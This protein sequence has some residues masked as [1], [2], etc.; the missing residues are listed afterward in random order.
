MFGFGMHR[1]SSISF[2]WH[3][4]GVCVQVHP[5]S[6][7]G[8]VELG[9]LLFKFHG[10]ISVEDHVTL[11]ACSVRA[12]RCIIL[13]RHDMMRPFVYSFSHVDRKWSH[14]SLALLGA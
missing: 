8:M 7:Y 5:S 11:L 3:W 12:M 13:L 14:M 4:H 9:G 6:H 10:L 1:M 2:A